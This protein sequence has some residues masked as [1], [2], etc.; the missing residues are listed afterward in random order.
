[1]TLDR[2]HAARPATRLGTGCAAALLLCLGLTSPV[3]AQNFPL[4]EGLRTILAETP[5]RYV[6]LRGLFDSAMDA[7]QGKALPGR[8]STCY[9][10]E[11]QGHGEYRC[12]QRMPD[13]E[14]TARAAFDTT[15]AEVKACLGSDLRPIR[16]TMAHRVWFRYE[17]GGERLSISYRRH[18]SKYAEIPPRYM[19]RLDISVVEMNQ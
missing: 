17:V 7:Y 4:C 3:R 14:A 9:T 8:F 1:M 15:V 18:V 6:K 10:T 13:D 12:E 19:L 5:T 2:E 16:G 11:S